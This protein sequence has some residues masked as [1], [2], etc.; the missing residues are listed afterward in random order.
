MRKS[1]VISAAFAV[2]LL[3]AGAGIWAAVGPSNPRPAMESAPTPSLTTVLPLPPVEVANE[4]EILNHQAS[5]LTVFRFAPNP[6]IL[7]LDFPDL[8]QQARMLNR[9]AALIEKKGLPRD[10]V[11]DDAALARVVRDGGGSADTFY[12][13]HDYSA[14]ELARFF[15]LADRDRIVLTPDEALLRRLLDREGFP[16]PGSMGA[17]LSVPRVGS[18]PSLD[19]AA[20]ATI[21]HHEL[22]HGEYFSN[23]AYAAFARAFFYGVMNDQDRAAMIRF[24]VAAGYDS[25]QDDLMINESQ[26]Y[27]VHTPESGF[28]DQSSLG[29]PAPELTRLRVAFLMGMPPGWPRDDS[30]AR[31]SDGVGRGP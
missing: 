11:L 8:A 14:Q 20:R 5:T 6:A 26:A 29:L 2:A 13:G 21:L 23:P 31:S 12:F 17:L 28:F 16:R 15:A 1:A 27:L 30:G 7:V 10:H 25:G 9:V 4:Q 3:V 22:S 18:A 19:L 24:L